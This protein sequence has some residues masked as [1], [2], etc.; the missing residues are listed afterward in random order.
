MG[1]DNI[2]LT[3]FVEPELTTI[4]QPIYEM[5]QKACEMLIDIINGRVNEKQ[6]CFY[7]QLI[8]RGTA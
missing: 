6:I 5:G 8:I 4:G 2:K 3:K 1:F 7:T